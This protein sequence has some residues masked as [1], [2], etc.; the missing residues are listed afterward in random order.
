VNVSTAC[1]FLSRLLLVHGSLTT[2]RLAR[3]VKYSFYKNASFAFM[4]FFYQIFCG[5]SGQAI[6][7]PHGT[8]KPCEGSKEEGSKH[9]R[10]P[11]HII[12]V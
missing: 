2:Y 7:I 11:T 9:H 6:L 5:F 1:R 3:L 12:F 4:L 8:S 10:Q